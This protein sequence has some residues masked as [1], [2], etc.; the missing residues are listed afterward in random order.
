MYILSELHESNGMHHDI[1]WTLGMQ[2]LK[3]SKEEPAAQTGNFFEE[4][5]AESVAAKW[6]EQTIPGYLEDK[7]TLWETSYGV[8]LPMKYHDCDRD[9]TKNDSFTTIAR[10][11]GIAAYAMELI[12]QYTGTDLY[13]VMK[14]ARKRET[15]A[16]YKRLFIRTINSVKP[17]LYKAL[18]D[19]RY[20]ET[21]GDFERGLEM[22]KTAITEHQAARQKVII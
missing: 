8:N 2:T 18:R 16:E 11:P 19:L 13:E 14:L 21:T 22:I 3:L 6:R 10:Y 20:D 7:I 17:G 15:E 1:H 12:S 4:A 5:F 9:P